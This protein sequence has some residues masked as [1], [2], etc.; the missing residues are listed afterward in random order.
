MIFSGRIFI[1]N[2]IHNNISGIVS[3]INNNSAQ[4]LLPPKGMG[5]NNKMKIIAQ[6]K[7]DVERFVNSI[8]SQYYIAEKYYS[9]FN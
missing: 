9:K 5:D 4:S 2:T 7:Y 6:Y 1:L 3:N 8:T